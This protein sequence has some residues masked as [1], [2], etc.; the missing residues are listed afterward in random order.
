[1]ISLMFSSSV[2]HVELHYAKNM[3]NY[4]VR[5]FNYIK[6]LFKKKICH[7]GVAGVLTTYITCVTCLAKT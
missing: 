5:L 3:V 4:M 6:F 7:S 1:M 2:D